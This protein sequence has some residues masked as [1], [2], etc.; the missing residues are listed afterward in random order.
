MFHYLLTYRKV[1]KPSHEELDYGEHRVSKV[2]ERI[3]NIAAD[4]DMDAANKAAEYIIRDVCWEREI[5]N[6]VMLWICTSI[7]MELA[8]K[9]KRMVLK[10]LEEQQLLRV[11]AE[12]YPDELE[13]KSKEGT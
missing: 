5:F 2:E 13:R 6:S 3:F 8:I 12:K 10:Q 9:N 4:N 1:I 7:D 11:L